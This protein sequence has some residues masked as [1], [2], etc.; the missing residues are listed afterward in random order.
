MRAVEDMPM[1]KL[2]PLLTAALLLALAG[3]GSSQFDRVSTG[4]G[5]G[6]ATGATIGLLGG[7]I[8]VGAG[9]LIG[10]GAGALAGGL[11]N[12]SQVNLGKPIWE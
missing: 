3:C 12:T 7:P 11:T 5:T 6:A 2:I 9:A 1:H 10:A 4:A 8:G